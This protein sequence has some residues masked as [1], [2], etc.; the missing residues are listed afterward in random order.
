MA[1]SDLGLACVSIIPDLFDDPDYWKGSYTSR[2]AA[3]RR[4]AFDYTRRMC[5]IALELSCPTMNL[6]PG[7]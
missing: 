3:V 7:I 4:K 1:Y 6:W 2:E 5:H